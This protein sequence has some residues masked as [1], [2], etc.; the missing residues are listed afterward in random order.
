VD[1]VEGC[2]LEVVEVELD[3]VE[4]WVVEVEHIVDDVYV[5]ED[6]VVGR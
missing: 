1:V 3:V 6:V 2:V 4:G 5:L